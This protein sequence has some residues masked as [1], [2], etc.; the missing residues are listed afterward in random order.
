MRGVDLMIDPTA[1]R[2]M[3][4]IIDSIEEAKEEYRKSAPG[5]SKSVRVSFKKE[6]YSPEELLD[7]LFEYGRKCD[8]IYQL[9]WS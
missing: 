4:G 9:R 2:K 6:K 8:Q 3:N 5:L 1:Q 7:K